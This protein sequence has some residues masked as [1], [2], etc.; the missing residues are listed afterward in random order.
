MNDPAP[1]AP[2]LDARQLVKSFP[3][4]GAG[5]RG[6]HV[7]A[8]EGVSLSI[9][10]GEV[11]GLVGESGCGKSTLGRMIAGAH[12][13]TSGTVVFDGTDVSSAARRRR[14]TMRQRVQMVFQDPYSSLDP[15]W[16]IGRII[17]EPLVAFHRGNRSARDA[18]V[19]E[20]FELVGLDPDATSRRPHQL[21]GGQRQR[22]AIARALA[23]G[24]DLLVCDEPIAA[25]DVSIQAQVVNL[26][27]D[28]R[29]KLELAILFIAHDLGMVRYLSDRVAVM[30][31]AKLVEVAPTDELYA[32]PLHPYTVGLLDAVPVPDP[33]IERN[34]TAPVIRGELPD[35]LAPPS[36]CRFA[37]RCPI[38]VDTC[39]TQEPALR[40]VASE[41]WVACDLVEPRPSLDV[42]GGSITEAVSP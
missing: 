15:R 31:L 19:R 22:V 34:R 9:A 33:D 42:P 2:L 36:G 7:R 16:T 20:L 35:P 8:V 10:K 30:Y 28:L 37:A 18:R 4:R 23:L 11:L 40:E 38:A 14:R 3:A 39:H 12:A 32:N 1:G 13:P 41:H 27:S 5:L 6:A 21:S 25:L 17:S 29:S 24:P 26:L